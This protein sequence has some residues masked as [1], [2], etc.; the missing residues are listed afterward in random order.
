MFPW[1]GGCVTQNYESWTPDRSEPI[2]GK[3]KFKSK[4]AESLQ[5]IYTFSSRPLRGSRE[6]CEDKEEEEEKRS[7][8]EDDE[9][10]SSLGGSDKDVREREGGK[11]DSLADS[12]CEV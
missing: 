6:A 8:R 5:N 4:F 11:L 10:S 3:T 12:N 1:S 2:R 7:E 9:G